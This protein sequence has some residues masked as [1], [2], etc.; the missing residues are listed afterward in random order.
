MTFELSVPEPPDAILEVLRV[1]PLGDGCEIEER[2]P[3]RASLG[4]LGLDR[5]D[6]QGRR[7]S[8]EKV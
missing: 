7:L 8:A 4:M 3:G 6:D 1:A 5:P 2:F